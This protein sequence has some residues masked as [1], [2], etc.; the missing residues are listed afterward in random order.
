[1]GLSVSKLHRGRAAARPFLIAA[2]QFLLRH[3][4]QSRNITAPVHL[5][6][7]NRGEAAVDG[8]FGFAKLSKI[9]SKYAKL[10]KL[11]PLRLLR[12]VKI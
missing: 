3:S 6:M 11:R 10:Q 9:V 12:F 1:M 2:F 7:F 5:I 8:V 4:K